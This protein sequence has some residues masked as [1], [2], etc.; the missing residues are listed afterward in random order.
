MRWSPTRR[1]FLG[2]LLGGAAAGAVGRSEAIAS[3]A[4]SDGGLRVKAT[5]NGVL[6][7]EVV[8]ENE[9]AL[10]YVRDR[11]G[12]KGTKLACGHGACGACTVNV[13]GV[14]VAS[15][16]MPATSLHATSVTTIEAV[17]A[18]GL[19]PIQRAFL[20][21]DALQCGFCTPGFIV[22]S[23]AFFEKWRA[24]H[25]L[26]TPSK[27]EVSDA[28]AGH[29]CRC[30]AYTSILT[31]VISACE[32]KYD[33]GPD[34]G[35]RKD[36]LEKVTGAAEYTVDVVLPG[37]LTGRMLRSPY[38]S[39]LVTKMDL[40]PALNVPGVRAV[41]RMVTEAGTV[42][43]VGQA[44]AAVA[45]DD[46][47]AAEAGLAAIVV[48]YD[49]REPVIGFDQALDLGAPLVYEP[50][51]RKEAPN[52]NEGPLFPAKWDGNV[53]GPAKQH[54]LQRPGAADRAVE[55]GRAGEGTLIEGDW[56]TQNQV[57]TPLEPRASVAWWDGSLLQVWQSTQS[58]SDLAKDLTERFELKADQVIVRAAYVGG[59]FGSKVGLDQGGMAAV[60]L[61]LQVKLPVRMVADR[62]EEM[63]IGGNRPGTRI[64][65]AIAADA[66]KALAGMIADSFVDSGAAVGSTLGMHFRLLVPG[67][68]RRLQ[69][70]DVVTN[71]PPGK[72]FRAP[73]GP[74]AFFAF[75]NALDEFAERFGEDVM[76][77]HRRWD[78]N[79]IRGRLYNVLE[80][81]PL[82]RDR[83][84]TPETGRYRRGVG[85]AH[86]GWVYFVNPK[87]PVRLDSGP[88][89]FTVSTAWQ[90][91]G[92]GTR[93]ILAV[94][95]AEVLGLQ[96]QDISVRI[97][98]TREV[99]GGMSAGSRTT[100]SLVPAARAA[101]LALV[102]DLI[103]AAETQLGY[104]DVALAPGGLTHR[105]GFLAWTDVLAALP[106]MST[107]QKRPK[108][109]KPW[110]IPF[111]FGGTAVGR[112]I[113]GSVVAAEVE[114]DTRLGKVRATRVWSGLGAGRIVS[115]AL[116]HSQATGGVLQGV[117]YA[118]YEERRLCPRTGSVLTRDLEHYH[119]ATAGDCPEIDIYFDEEGWE[120]ANGGPI[121]LSE[122]STC[123]VAGA[124]GCGV[125]AATGWRP[126]ELPISPERVLAGL[127]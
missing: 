47:A 7:D 109:D 63:T 40:T 117:S 102:D 73:A 46:A 100:A 86:A 20:A 56:A 11:C 67:G 101:A 74:P 34:F 126:R 78:Q 120:G 35:P 17:A 94:A 54:I 6:R 76:T 2:G 41:V 64:H 75:A 23:V 80:R 83:P 50:K 44:L 38:A 28:L 82:W 72:P 18:A 121:G 107:I 16:V 60:E 106:A 15:C 104:V 14:P 42:R 93:T 65:L 1:G 79:P 22:E 95:V 39:A 125:R 77:V 87:T 118:L 97:G 3:E 12:F 30:G 25:G 69:D 66:N 49:V 62:E 96:P 24:E 31:A 115:P 110:F 113:T 90:D 105:R 8:G 89:G 112:G 99:G 57:H 108:D 19:H 21:E 71:S 9:M 116:A 84:K 37:M 61:S 10:D 32:G 70:T 98:D 48:E 55:A 114:V 52:A 53:R 91:M 92:N 122:L 85:L 43:Y 127:S 36:G 29:I 26:S 68:E 119:I 33:T 111:T 45:A 13:D 58:I 27:R 81:L 5:V 59:G 124:V 88:D 103:E 4:L 123:G 51:D